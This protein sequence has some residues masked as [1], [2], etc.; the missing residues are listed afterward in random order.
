MLIYA[1]QYGY[2][3]TSYL[4]NYYKERH[5]FS[6]FRKEPTSPLAVFFLHCILNAEVVITSILQG[7]RT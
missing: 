2:C 7:N 3:A 5:L 1:S 6:V 4:F